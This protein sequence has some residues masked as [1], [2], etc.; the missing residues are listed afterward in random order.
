[1]S[2]SFIFSKFDMFHLICAA[3][4]SMTSSIAPMQGLI[5]I[6]ERE[7]PPPFSLYGKAR[8]AMKGCTDRKRQIVYFIN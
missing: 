4:S 1:M 5:S 6:A 7:F 2:G 8:G 3:F